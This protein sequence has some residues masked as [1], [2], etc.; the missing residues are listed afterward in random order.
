M[1]RLLQIIAGMSIAAVAVGCGDK[2]NFDPATTT[3]T[4]PP[5]VN[6][7]ITRVGQPDLEVQER[8]VPSQNKNGNFGNPIPTQKL[9]FSVL[10]TAKDAQSGIRNIKLSMTRTV[11]YM[12][13]GGVLA[14]AYFG[15]VVRK[16][17]TYTDPHNAPVQP[18][19]GDTGIIDNSI[20]HND[21]AQPANLNDDNLLVWKN[22]NQQRNVGVG[23]STKW[24]LEATNFS[25]TT[26][27]SDVIFIVAG[28]TT[29]VTQP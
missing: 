13:T 29:C 11:C 10:A 9:T 15:S 26:T 23:V 1:R 28:D 5:T 21:P 3:D 7:L 8:V 25:G 14:Q 18:S 16:E 6:L 20:L 24:F 22:A 17:A 27:Y 4:T 19:V 12:S 2:V